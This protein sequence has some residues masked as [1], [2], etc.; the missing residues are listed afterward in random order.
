MFDI[1]SNDPHERLAVI[2][3]LRRQ[4][5][6]Y[7]SAL[8][9]RACRLTSPVIIVRP[10]LAPAVRAPVRPGGPSAGRI[11]TTPAALED[12]TGFTPPSRGGRADDA[13]NADPRHLPTAR[14]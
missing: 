3:T 6:A 12:T 9:Q 2:V 13:L 8:V 5:I 4:I 1:A 11:A 7:H 14:R 10:V